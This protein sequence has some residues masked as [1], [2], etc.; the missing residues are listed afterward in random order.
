MIDGDADP[1]FIGLSVVHF[2]I[3][4]LDKMMLLRVSQ[5]VYQIQIL[6]TYTFRTPPW[7]NSVTL[8]FPVLWMKS[9]SCVSMLTANITSVPNFNLRGFAKPSVF[10][11][12]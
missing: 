1:F 8:I 2:S 4:T 7:P 3:G 5:L 12:F 10:V 9:Q 6:V 11:C